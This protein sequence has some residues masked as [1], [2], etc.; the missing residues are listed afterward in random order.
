MV[1]IGTAVLYNGRRNREGATFYDASGELLA[2]L[3][4][5]THLERRVERALER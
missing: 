4:V 2:F 3:G 1:G 5:V